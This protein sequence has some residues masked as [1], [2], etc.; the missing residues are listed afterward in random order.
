MPTRLKREDDIDSAYDYSPTAQRLANSETATDS[1]YINKGLE[2]AKE[3]VN[4]PNN[5]TNQ[6]R[7][8]ENDA[9]DANGGWT[10]NRS[11]ESAPAPTGLKAFKVAKK[12]G[13]AAAI[14]GILLALAGMVSFVGGPGL[15]IVQF[16]ETITNK[17]DSRIAS[18]EN[19]KI[20][21]L[22]KKLEVTTNGKCTGLVTFRCKYTTFS[23]HDVAAFKSAGIE[24]VGDKKSVLGRTKGELLRF[25]DP[26]SGK[27]IE[28]TAKNFDSMIKTNTAFRNATIQ[29]YNA[30]FISV[31][32]TA[33]MKSLRKSKTSYGDQFDEKDTTEEERD[34]RISETTKEGQA[35]E[36]PAPFQQTDKCNADCTAE[37]NKA[38]AAA[39]QLAASAEDVAKN[40]IKAAQPSGI[41]S[42]VSAA[43]TLGV[44]DDVCTAPVLMDAIGTGAKV[45]RSQQEIRYAMFF[46]NTAS[47]IKNG[48]AT[49]GNVSHLGN[50]LTKV[51]K[52]AKGNMTKSA[53]DSASYRYAAYG[54]KGTTNSSALFKVG[55]GLGGEM[56]GLA[57]NLFKA[58]G[59]KKTCDVLGN[60]WVQ[61]AGILI[62][63]IPGFGQAAKLGTVAV[64]AAVKEALKTLAKTAGVAIG[65]SEIISYLLPIATDLVAGVLVD[66]NTFGE[67]SGDAGVIGGAEFHTQ[68]SG[69]GG[70]LPLTPDQAVAYNEH[71]QTVLA[72]YNAYDQATL[73]PFDTSSQATFL[74]SITAQLVPYFA[75]MTTVGGTLSSVAAMPLSTFANL[76]QPIKAHAADT[77]DSYRECEDYEY[78]EMDVAT[79]PMCNVL[80]GIP[81]KYLAIDP[82]TLNAELIQSGDIDPTTGDPLS[83][84]YKKFVEDCL[85]GNVL[86]ADSDCLIKDENADRNGRF[87]VHYVDQGMVDVMENGLPAS[88]A[89]A[90]IAPASTAV[91]D[92]KWPLDKHF[93][94]QN[95]ADW[96][97]PH[98]MWSGTFTDPY[99]QGVADDISSSP[100]GTPIYSMFSGTVE[101]INLCKEGG[102]MIVSSNVAGGILNVAYGHGTDPKFTAG[103][104]VTAG[105]QILSL[106][107]VGCKTTGPHLHI[108]M[109]FNS[110]HICPQ[111]VFIAMDAGQTPDFQA[112]TA[113]ANPG[114]TGRG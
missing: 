76:T 3:Y 32:D 72:M 114:C 10:V 30:K 100:K 39:D 108:D 103:Q 7:S 68:T 9:T 73:S 79:T 24:V 75:N 27:P 49:P 92:I 43:N 109:S 101:R 71:Q 41:K 61:G 17:F 96:L 56:T 60:P 50:I 35:I 113:K 74:G 14:L 23:D 31:R 48:T 83:D 29:A 112:L 91:G 86:S 28:V 97:G 19:R 84:T 13:P 2:D 12:G 34:K 88:T 85:S 51:V 38:V 107:G 44:V 78:R 42:L 53:T 98:T 46:L 36:R 65:M 111:D 80:R 5:A 59:G 93:F 62:N 37:K 11:G 8:R 81:A 15:L 77:A 54:D 87:A 4:D 22:H 70:N 63:F 47:K 89:D 104:P 25:K 18:A 26:G 33:A 55:G 20:K 110:K 64:R 95:K 45:I 69:M 102:G 52:D 90:N 105:Q 40:N 106:D 21:I 58:V 16:A 99:V 1:D 6:L 66:G 57:S 82:D 67:Q 94:D